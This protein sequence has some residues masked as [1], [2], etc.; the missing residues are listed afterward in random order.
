MVY[1]HPPLATIEEI[2][3]PWLAGGVAHVLPSR[4]AK[5]RLE[6]LDTAWT[7]QTLEKRGP[8]SSSF[9][10]ALPRV[11]APCQMVLAL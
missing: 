10:I 7:L 8:L 9:L 5:Q 6:G 2:D 11:P 1:E 4:S 3:F